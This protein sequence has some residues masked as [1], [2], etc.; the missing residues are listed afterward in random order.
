MDNNRIKSLFGNRRFSSIER[1]RERELS[2]A[3]GQGDIILQ[4]SKPKSRLKVVFFVLLGLVLVTGVSLTVF[5][6][7]NSN[8]NKS[9]GGATNR[10]VLELMENSYS[11]TI[12]I[13]RFFEKG[14][15][16]NAGWSQ[17]FSEKAKNRVESS[18][19]E[20]QS[21]SEDLGRYDAELISDEYVREKFLELKNIIND[22]LLLYGRLV[23]IYD[24]FYDYI[25]NNYNQELAKRISGYNDVGIDAVLRKLDNAVTTGGSYTSCD[26][27][28][29]IFDVVLGDEYPK[30]YYHKLIGGIIGGLR[31]ENE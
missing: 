31:Y 24:A 26:V 20:I 22:D 17:C 5:L 1:E 4:P 2:S 28:Y 9:D 16:G 19:S 8:K 21:F 18:L 10:A 14:K 7:I 3:P 23:E 27:M 12:S 29:G 30:I 25:A 6:W 11:T 13:Q 15:S